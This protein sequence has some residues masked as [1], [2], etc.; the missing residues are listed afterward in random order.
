ME[1]GPA[2]MADSIPE[3]NPKPYPFCG[4]AK[5]KPRPNFNPYRDVL[6]GILS[7]AALVIIT[8]SSCGWVVL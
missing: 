1:N 8:S 7:Y 2:Y 3:D 5:D 6:L 4:L